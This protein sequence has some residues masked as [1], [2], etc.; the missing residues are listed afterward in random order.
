MTIGCSHQD[1][2]KLASQQITVE[3]GGIR[4]AGEKML[5]WVCSQHMD[6]PTFTTSR[7]TGLVQRVFE[8]AGRS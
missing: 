2:T 1:C 5:V 4:S 6:R 8:F 7:R 3:L